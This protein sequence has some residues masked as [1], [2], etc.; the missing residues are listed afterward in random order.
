MHGF[1]DN[2]IRVEMPYNREA[3][4]KVRLVRLG[5]FNEAGDALTAQ[6]ID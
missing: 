4:N 2:Y 6:Y 5:E 1:T 3:I